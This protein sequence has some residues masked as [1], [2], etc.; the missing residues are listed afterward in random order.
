MTPNKTTISRLHGEQ[1]NY[2][3]V[4]RQISQLPWGYMASK[5]ALLH[6]KQDSHVGVDTAIKSVYFGRSNDPLR[7][8]VSEAVNY[9]VSGGVKNN[10]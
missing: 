6:G 3:R 4:T 2:F 8:R 10:K 5:P 7:E 9:P 1:V